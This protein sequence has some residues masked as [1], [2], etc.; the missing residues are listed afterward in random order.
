MFSLNSEKGRQQ[1]KVNPRVSEVDSSILGL[2]HRCKW[3]FQCKLKVMSNSVDPDEMAHNATSHLDL[4][5]LQKYL[6]LSTRLK[7]LSLCVYLIFDI[8]KDCI[9]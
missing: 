9:I 6:S 8:V 7:N 3:R 5:C 4:H 1:T 2:L